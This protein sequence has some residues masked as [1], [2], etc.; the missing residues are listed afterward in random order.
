MPNPPQGC[1]YLYGH[2]AVELFLKA[3][4][5]VG[6]IHANLCKEE[7]VEVEY[8]TTGSWTR[9]SPPMATR[10]WSWSSTMMIFRYGG[11][12]EA[13]SEELEEKEETKDEEEREKKK[14]GVTFKIAEVDVRLRRHPP[15]HSQTDCQEGRWIFADKVFVT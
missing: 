14:H 11:S 13:E 9:S 4:D 3:N 1:S 10:W 12:Y 2:G 6:M 7:G 15:S 5:L 8:T